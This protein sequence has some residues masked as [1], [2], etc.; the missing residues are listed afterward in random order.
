ML[1]RSLIKEIIY[2]NKFNGIDLVHSIM[3]AE[4]GNYLLLG[5]TYGYVD[6]WG[7]DF[8]PHIIK[9][10]STGEVIWEKYIFE[11][12]TGGGFFRTIQSVIKIDQN[13]YILYIFDDRGFA[14]AQMN[15][16]GEIVQYK[17]A[18]GYPNSR[19]FTINKEGKY[20]SLTDYGI[21]IFNPDGYLEG[22]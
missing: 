17:K 22:L 20:V 2:P 6:T 14:I 15:D 3:E 10:D 16:K 18:N 13:N 4:K 12:E 7:V 1:F 9:I 8:C 11:S 19:H 21:I 5:S